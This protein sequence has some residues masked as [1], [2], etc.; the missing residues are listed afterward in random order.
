M[1]LSIQGVDKKKKQPTHPA[2]HNILL[3]CFLF[4][5]TMITKQEA[6]TKISELVTRFDE[7]ID[8]YKQSDYNET[9]TRRMNCTD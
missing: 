7:Q 5:T 2:C 6:Y 4:I 1:D 8:S 3:N 9:L